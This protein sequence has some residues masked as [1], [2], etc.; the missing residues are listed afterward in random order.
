MPRPARQPLA[1]AFTLALALASA[2]CAREDDGGHDVRRRIQLLETESGRRVSVYGFTPGMDYTSAAER[3][4]GDT[5]GVF[6][7]SEG[8]ITTT[9]RPADFGTEVG[10]LA[11]TGEGRVTHLHF[12]F[13]GE[14]RALERLEARIREALAALPREERRPGGVTWTV[15]ETRHVGLAWRSHQGREELTLSVSDL[16]LLK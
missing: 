2:A 14:R 13:D 16:S 8:P 6:F 9:G 11:M 1:V 15:T 7:G 10:M 12:V 5:I 3:A 4:G